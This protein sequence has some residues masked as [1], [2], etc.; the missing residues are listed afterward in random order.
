MRACLYRV[1]LVFFFLFSLRS[2][3][4]TDLVA[5]ILQHSLNLGQVR[6]RLGL[7]PE[8]GPGLL[9]GVKRSSLDLPLLLELAK[10]LLVLPSDTMGEV[11]EDREVPSGTKAR[12]AKGGRDDLPLLLVERVRDA[13]KGGEP[14]DGS[15]ATGSL[16]VHHAAHRAPEHL[17]RSLKVEGSLPGVG[18]HALLAELSVL[19]AVANDG[20]GDAH[21][22]AS[23]DDDLLTGE[24]LLGHHGC[25]TA[26][27]VVAAVDDDGGFQN[28]N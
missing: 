5:R 27:K 15:L 12:D 16:L 8:R 23:D 28:L 25:Q 6:V 7:G 11:P 4:F 24:E 10:Q 18:V 26:E 9:L 13:V 3:F 17:G 14:A 20:A 21:L 22:V 19:D 2:G 1:K